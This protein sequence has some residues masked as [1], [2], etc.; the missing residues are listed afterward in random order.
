M[1]IANMV[2]QPSAPHLHVKVHVKVVVVSPVS[3]AVRIM[4][5]RV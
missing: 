1:A 3:T 2:A 4:A 5:V